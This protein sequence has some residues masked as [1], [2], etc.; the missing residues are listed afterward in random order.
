MK[1]NRLNRYCQFLVVILTI[2]IAAGT[3][4][5]AQA[6]KN[7][8][9]A[10]AGTLYYVSRSTGSDG[11]S[12]SQQNPWR[13][14]Q[15]AANAMPSGSTVIVLDGD[16]P[17]R[18]TIS[19]SNLS[20]QAQGDVTM[21]GFKV[22]ADNVSISGFTITTLVDN[23]T[24]G[25]G[26][27]VDTGGNCLIENN[28]FLYNTWGGLNLYSETN[29]PNRTHDCVVRNNTFFRNGI[30]AA[31][32]N[33]RNHLIENNDVSQSIQHHPCSNST[34]SWLDADAF[35]IHGSGHV[36]R[37]NNIHG[38]SFG[39]AGFDQTGCSI[40]NLSNLSN[41]Y[42][43]D[44]HID[45]FQTY[46]GDEIA[47]H[48]ILFEGNRCE[49]PSAAEWRDGGAAKA[50]QGEGNIY[51]LTIKNNV[52][53]ADLLSVFEGNCHDLTI[54]HN[55]FIGSGQTYSQGLQLYGCS[56]NNTI[57]NNVFYRQENGIGHIWAVNAQVNAGYNCIYNASGTPNR[58]PDT[59]DV[60]DIDPRLDNN[61]R[62]LPD[63]P[64]IDA[65]TDLGVNID[66]DGNLRPQLSGPD[67]GAFERQHLV[68]SIV[69]ADPDFTSAASVDYI[70]TF[71]E[72]VTGV[73][74]T[75]FSLTTTGDIN[76]AQPS[77]ITGAGTT[78]T[79]SVQTGSGNGTIRM[80]VIDDNSIINATG[81]PLGGN[82]EHDGDYT[83]GEVYLVDHSPVPP[84]DL[85]DN[86]EPISD[87]GNIYTI[88]TT[89][90][91]S[92]IDDPSIDSCGIGQGV[93]TV[94]YTYTADAD[95]AIT[96]DTFGSDYDTFIAVW[97]DDGGLK[98][99]ACNNNA[100]STEQSSVALQVANGTTYFV[101]IGKPNE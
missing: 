67:I 40:A 85:I 52:I 26:I 56:G 75:D 95:T 62:L 6:T 46:D 2:L 63:S 10:Y 11:N 99:L 68:Q 13:T 72:S 20:F 76:G 34:A 87:I 96:F 29:S 97:V 101:E 49:L 45:C 5:N 77:G 90:A 57:K 48:D 60:W 39:H 98:L 82:E 65:G 81:N 38:F 27:L 36:F 69:R 86:P 9:R 66:F 3:P 12:G 91:T 37:G 25:I 35:R 22:L 41:D 84:N 80:D 88:R 8:S 44:S 78:Y 55:T 28:A 24:D 18:V 15:K 83:E 94:W 100:G 23:F 54:I 51:N 50:F 71:Y 59:G 42:I 43:S 4:L 33:G 21:Q 19:R 61:Y 74:L 32:I 89:R 30:Y 17:E 92:S 93:G 64:C 31:E 47:G 79:V 53:I 7:I 70:V 73:D 16:Y 14:I 58:P 1:K